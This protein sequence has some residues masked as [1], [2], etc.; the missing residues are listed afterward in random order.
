MTVQDLIDTLQKI[1]DKSLFVRVLE[2]KPFSDDY[3]LE[4]YWIDRIDVANTGQSG[5]ELHGEVV[6]IGES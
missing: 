6:L 3:N 2:N 5:Y 4:N 1:K